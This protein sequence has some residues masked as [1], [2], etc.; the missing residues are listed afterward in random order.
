MLLDIMDIKLTNHFNNTKFF[1]CNTSLNAYMYESF[2]SHSPI[3][4]DQIIKRASF[5][6]SRK[7]KL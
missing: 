4:D 1:V 2:D 5:R 6:C 7:L 3:H